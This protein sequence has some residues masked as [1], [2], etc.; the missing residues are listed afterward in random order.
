MI[1]AFSLE[2]VGKAGAKF[3]A[4]KAKWFNQ[5]YLRSK[6]NEE[7]AVLMMPL[8][9]EKGIEVDESFA[10]GVANLMKERATFIPDLVNAE[11]FFGKPE[12]YDKKTIKK[13]WKENTPE[14]MKNLRDVL[15][16]IEGFSHENIETEFKNFL[17]KNELG[18]GAVLPNFRVLVTGQ[19]MGASMSEICALLGKEEVLSR[20]DEGMKSVP[21]ILETL[22][23]NA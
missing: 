19:G 3:D 10:A 8:L 22:R 20:M 6:S 1:E 13:K 5:Q 15:A 4:D 11:Y 16:G 18:F 9:Q 2:R 21:Q 7:L 14:H 17:E 12:E 23:S